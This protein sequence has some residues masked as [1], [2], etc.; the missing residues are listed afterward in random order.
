[1]QTSP[2]PIRGVVEGFYGVFYTVP[3]RDDLIRFLG[4]HGFNFYLYGPKNDRHHRARWRTPYPPALLAQFA[5]SVAEA[6]AA[7]VTF[8]YALSPGE[9]FC[10]AAADDFAAL[11]AKLH[12][13]YDCGVRAFALFL[14]DITPGFCCPAERQQ[15]P[16]YAAAH[17]ALANRV[18]AWLHAL[19]GRCRLFLCPTDYAGVAP[20][21]PYLH[22]LGQRLDTAVDVFYTGP[23][24]CAA[25]I[26][27]ADAAAFARAVRRPPLIWDN[28]PVND[29]AMTAEMHLGPLRGRAADLHTATRGYVAN[30]MLQPEASKIPLLTI[31]DYLADPAGYRPEASWERA[32]RRVG[33]DASY[34]ALRL[35][36]DNVRCSVLETADEEPVA[37][38]TT[39]A[40]AA[41]R[42]G[43][44]AGESAAVARLEHH[45]RALDEAGY[46]LKYY[47]ANLAL[48]YDLLP[49]LEVLDRGQDMARRGLEVLRAREQDQPYERP[50]RIMREWQ[51]AVARHPRY[52]ANAVFLS[53]AAYVE[54]QLAPDEAAVAPARP[55]TPSY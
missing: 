51:T 27:T 11:T 10:F 12:S 47:A 23:A 2:F 4:R 40:L 18:A 50:L 49:W 46:H 43:E 16:G 52:V 22:E 20:F 39:V 9:S 3:Q 36:A 13:L 33:G 54:A 29:L 41:L 45:L 26:E 5:H 21:T 28:Y 32:L 44:R 31:A 1:M 34:A 6:R 30:L 55:V 37:T 42:R 25:R 14:D 35:F 17:A 24:V 38:L 8:C 7:G 15:Y 53:V 48:R 19:D